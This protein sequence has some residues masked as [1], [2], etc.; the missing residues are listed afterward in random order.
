MLLL[1]ADP[2]PDGW[3]SLQGSLFRRQGPLSLWPL[4]SPWLC[5]SLT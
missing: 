1:R 4:A 2:Y 3:L 5:M